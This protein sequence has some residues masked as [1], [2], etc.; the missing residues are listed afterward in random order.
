MFVHLMECPCFV[1]FFCQSN[2]IDPSIY[3]LS[4]G[5]SEVNRYVCVRKI[6]IFKTVIV[7]NLVVPPPHGLLHY[8]HCCTPPQTTIPI[9]HCTDDTHTH[10]H[11]HTHTQLI[12]L[13]TQLIAL[14]THLTYAIDF[15]S[16]IAEYCFSF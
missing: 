12:A 14:I 7:T 1:L 8:T 11:T 3:M 15:L 5:L 4:I 10:T 6:S 16:V 9:I 2:P 13:I